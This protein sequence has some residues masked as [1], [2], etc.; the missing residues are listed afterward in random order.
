MATLGKIIPL[1]PEFVPEP[2][3]ATEPAQL[4]D[5]IIFTL[6]VHGRGEALPG[7][8]STASCQWCGEPWPC[9]PICLAAGL[10]GGL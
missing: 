7:P 5:R 10:L 4:Y 8:D 3:D 9:G 1:K 6:L 2:S